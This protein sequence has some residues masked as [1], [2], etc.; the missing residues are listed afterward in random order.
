MHS[1]NLVHPTLPNQTSRPA[2][3]FQAITF[4]PL[5]IAEE[6][7]Y[8]LWKSSTLS[9]VLKNTITVISVS[10]EISL[11]YCQFLYCIKLRLV[12]PY[13]WCCPIDGDLFG[14]LRSGSVA[15]WVPFPPLYPHSPF[16]KHCNMEMPHRS[17]HIKP[18]NVKICFL[19]TFHN[20]GV[21]CRGGGG[22][23]RTISVR[24]KF[25]AI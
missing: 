20:F 23:R 1:R 3:C 7:F 6:N 2:I 15:W 25:Y 16:C 9:Q 19:V 4:L 17:W 18:G 12:G 24:G 5:V 21:A 8:Y 14:W 10:T 22:G 13:W 11:L